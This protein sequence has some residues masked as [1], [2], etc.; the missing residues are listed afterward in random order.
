MLIMYE[1]SLATVSHYAVLHKSSLMIQS[2]SVYL[3]FIFWKHNIPMMQA[4]QVP[5]AEGQEGANGGRDLLSGA[6][7]RK[8]VSAKYYREFCRDRCTTRVCDLPP[9]RK[10]VRKRN[11]GLESLFQR[12]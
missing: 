9:K 10:K 4:K 8:Q 6:E 3:S 11:T 12:Q 1:C 2:R 5:P 7:R